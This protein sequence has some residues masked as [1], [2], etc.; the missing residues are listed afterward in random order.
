MRTSVCICVSA[1]AYLRALARVCSR[2]GVTFP[3][4]QLLAGLSYE[5]YSDTLVAATMGRGVYALRPAK[6]ALLSARKVAVQSA[7]AAVPEQSSAQFF[8]TQHP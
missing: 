6:E 5:H 4:A 8:P 7:P 1:L 3:A 2:G